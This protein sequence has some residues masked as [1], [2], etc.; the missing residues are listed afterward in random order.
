MDLQNTH[1]LYSHKIIVLWRENSYFQHLLNKFLSDFDQTGYA[2]LFMT[3]AF[4]YIQI[5]GMGPI[6]GPQGGKNG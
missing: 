1:E 5:R 6:W 3:R 2:W 4:M